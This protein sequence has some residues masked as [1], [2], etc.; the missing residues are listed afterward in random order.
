MSIDFTNLTL[1]VI[2]VFGVFGWARGIRRVA[3]ATGSIFFA[4]ALVELIGTPLIQELVRLGFAF[5]PAEEANLLLA[6]LF[7]FA[8]YAVYQFG[9]RVVLGSGS[10]PRSR[11]DRVTGALL[12]LL[13]GFLVFATAVRYAEPF[14]TAVQGAQKEGWSTTLLLPHLGHPDAG[15]FSFSLSQTTI[16][17]R[18][19]P[20]LRSYES[21]PTAVVILF[22][23]V[24]LVFLG[25]AYGRVVRGRG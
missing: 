24:V 20:M 22:A 9:V 21:V 14:L 25:T 16:T 19:S 2:V 23:F 6:A 3:L 5:H 18:P 8:I 11:S 7:V 13:N 15:T 4:M 17:L 10:G 1:A 12:G